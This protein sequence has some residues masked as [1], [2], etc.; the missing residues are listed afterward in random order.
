[1][2]FAVPTL[3]K[4]WF[5]FRFRLRFWFRIQTTFSTVFQEQKDCT[6]FSYFKV[7]N[8]LFPKKL[9]SHC[10]SYLMKLSGA[11]TGAVI[12]ICGS[13]EPEPKE[14]FSAPQ[15]CTGP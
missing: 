7:R 5:R 10:A 2:I 1:M 13:A 15:H 3:Q 8:S 9:A 4:F 6:K 11:G 14:I 12:Q